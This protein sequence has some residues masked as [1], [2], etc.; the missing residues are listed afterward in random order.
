MDQPE[1]AGA[2]RTGHNYLD[3]R[4]SDVGGRNTAEGSGAVQHG[5]PEVPKN[6]PLGFR[7]DVL[8]AHL[9]ATPSHCTAGQEHV[10]PDFPHVAFIQSSHTLG[11]CVCVCVCVCVCARARA[12]ACV[13]A[14]SPP[15]RSVTLHNNFQVKKGEEPRI[16]VRIPQLVQVGPWTNLE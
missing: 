5:G 8:P 6:F 10:Q 16:P 1:T 14:H 9:H 4:E 3:Q 7:E 2:G 12:R 13:R 11:K 15:I